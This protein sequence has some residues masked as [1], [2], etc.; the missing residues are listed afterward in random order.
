[1]STSYSAVILSKKHDLLAIIAGP[2][3]PRG[4]PGNVIN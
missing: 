2:V 4:C 1:M 3:A